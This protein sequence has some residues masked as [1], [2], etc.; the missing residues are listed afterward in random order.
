MIL[1]HDDLQRDERTPVATSA[2]DAQPTTVVGPYMNI[3]WI[4]GNFGYAVNFEQKFTVLSWHC[5]E[6]DS[7]IGVE[8]LN[9][10]FSICARITHCIKYI[11]S[12]LCGCDKKLIK[13]S[14][15]NGGKDKEN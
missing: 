1:C 15:N 11:W 14:L 7:C 5:T 9:L 3:I 13:Y 12:Y 8:M 2:I 4:F 6:T 10:F